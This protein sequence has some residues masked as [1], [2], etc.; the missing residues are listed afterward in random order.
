[1]QKPDPRQP[2]S[3]STYSEGDV[4]NI[5]VNALTKIMKKSGLP[6][7]VR[8]DS[9]KNKNDTQSPFVM[10]IKE[11]QKVLPEEFRKFTNSDY[12]L[13]Q[14]ISRARRK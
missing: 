10:F 7:Q 5:W 14:A 3:W 1:M 4:W 11:F 6:Y 12:A 13:A 2:S 9:D 8:K